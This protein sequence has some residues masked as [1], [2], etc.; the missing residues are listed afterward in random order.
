VDTDTAEIKELVKPDKVGLYTTVSN[1]NASPDGKMIAVE[2]PGYIDILDVN[3]KTIRRNVVPYTPGLLSDGGFLFL[4]DTFWLP[5]SSELIVVVPDGVTFVA[6]LEVPA[7]SIWQYNINTAAATQISLAPSL[8]YIPGGYICGGYNVSPDRKWILYLGSEDYTHTPTGDSNYAL[9]IRNLQNGQTQRVDIRFCGRHLWGPDSR[10]FLY[11][12]ILNAIDRP[13]IEI[14]S[15]N[16]IG[17]VDGFH[18]IFPDDNPSSLE[19]KTLVAEIR[20]D[21]VVFFDLGIRFGDL[22][23]IKSN[24]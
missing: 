24:R 23:T 19:T 16:I 3:G 17:W 7:Y 11:G 9:Y 20:G 10:H 18:F 22:V 21:T 4:P 14:K 12:N 1:F 13:S 15:S 8:V 6:E 5:D 2:Y